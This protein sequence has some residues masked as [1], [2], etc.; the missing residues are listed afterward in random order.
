MN[1]QTKGKDAKSI[2]YSLISISSNFILIIFHSLKPD[3]F[4]EIIKN[5]ILWLYI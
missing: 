5:F 4:V 3:A 2:T 1:E